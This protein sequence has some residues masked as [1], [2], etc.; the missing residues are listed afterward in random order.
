V[1]EEVTIVIFRRWKKLN[2]VFDPVIAMF[3]REPAG[4]CDASCLSYEHVGQHGA[5]DYHHVMSR[6]IVAEPAE[7]APLKHELEQ[8]GY[9]L[10]VRKRASWKDH[11]AR[12]NA[13]QRVWSGRG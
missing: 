11:Q 12:R 6:T 1:D 2:P 4:R 9:R 10:V 5:A 8:R 3:P 13:Q 7:Y